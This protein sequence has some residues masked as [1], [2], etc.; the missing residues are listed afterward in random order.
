MEFE[1]RT[2]F[3]AIRTSRR[4]EYRPF[5]LDPMP[6]FCFFIYSFASGL[7]ANG[8]NLACGVIIDD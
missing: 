2:R 6:L 1:P 4:V 5:S 8:T 3:Y 7:S